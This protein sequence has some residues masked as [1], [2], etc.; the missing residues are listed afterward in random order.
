MHRNHEHTMYSKRRVEERVLENISVRYAVPQ[1]TTSAMEAS[2]T[3]VDHVSLRETIKN[4]G[5]P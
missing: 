1:R 2:I 5:E 4:A 3:K